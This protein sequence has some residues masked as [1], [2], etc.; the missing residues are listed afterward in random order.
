MNPTPP[1]LRSPLSAHT[2]EPIWSLWFMQLFQYLKTVETGTFPDITGRLEALEA[3]VAA[4][5][6]RIGVLEGSVSSLLSQVTA[7]DNRVT[8]IENSFN[9][10]G[11]AVTFQTDPPVRIIYEANRWKGQVYINDDWQTCIKGFF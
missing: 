11:N 8:T 6:E 2:V 3:A 7:I 4:L 1:P 9:I 10:S 5:T